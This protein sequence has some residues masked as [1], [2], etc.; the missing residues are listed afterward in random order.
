[1]TAKNR[2]FI[3]SVL[4]LA[5]CSMAPRN[6]PADTAFQHVA[7]AA[8]EC[9]T[10]LLAQVRHLD[11]KYRVMT[12]YYIKNQA[13]DTTGGKVIDTQVREIPA[14]NADALDKGE[15]GSA[16]RDCMKQKNALAPE[17]VMSQS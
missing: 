8:N 7:R 11:G 17:I 9:T 15:T 1:M 5:A 6:E 16:W 14:I 3:I 4:T 12:R 10:D 13:V 2:I